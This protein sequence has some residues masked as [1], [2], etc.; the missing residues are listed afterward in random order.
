LKYEELKDNMI[1]TVDCS[2]C[3]FSE[4]HDCQ[5]YLNGQRLLASRI[6]SDNKTAYVDARNTGYSPNGSHCPINQLWS[7]KKDYSVAIIDNEVKNKILDF[8][9]DKKESINDLLRSIL[10]LN[11]EENEAKIRNIIL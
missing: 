1:V 9:K 2:G 8:A 3:E 7:S 4:D 11:L 6:K 10:G 5:K